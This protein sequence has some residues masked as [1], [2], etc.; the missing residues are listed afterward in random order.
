MTID[1]KIKFIIRTGP[2]LESEQVSYKVL[3]NIHIGKLPIMLKSSVCILEQYKHIPHTISGECKMDSGAISL[4]MGRKKPAWDKNAQLKIWY[5]V[6][7]FP[8]TIAS[9][10]G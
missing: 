2:K 10:A 4:L 8:K 9:G 3:S 7:T 5:N 1:L 6:S